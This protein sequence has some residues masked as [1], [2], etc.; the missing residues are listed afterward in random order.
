VA[1]GAGLVSPFYLIIGFLDVALL[2]FLMTAALWRNR[3][4]TFHELSVGVKVVTVIAV[5]YVI[6]T[7]LLLLDV[8]PTLGFSL[9]IA[10]YIISQLV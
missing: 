5:L 2:G 8:S 9:L 10:L 4:K 3:D 1:V 7:L 6:G